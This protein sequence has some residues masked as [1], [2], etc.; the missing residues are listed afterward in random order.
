M[1]TLPTLT[2]LLCYRRRLTLQMSSVLVGGAEYSRLCGLLEAP[3]AS[4]VVSSSAAPY[5]VEGLTP[6]E[7]KLIALNSCYGFITRYSISDGH[8]QGVTYPRHVKGHITGFPNNVQELVKNVLPHPL[9][10]VLDDIHVSWQ[11]AVPKRG[12]DD[13]D[14]IDIQEIVRALLK[15]QNAPGVATGYD[16]VNR[17][18][19]RGADDKG[20]RLY[21][22]GS[23]GIFDLDGWPDITDAGK[24]RHLLE[25]M[26]VAAVWHDRVAEPCIAVSRGEDFADHFDTWYLPRA[27]P[28]LL[29]RGMGGPRQVEE[30]AVA[31]R[32][33]ALQICEAEFAVRR[34]VS[35]RN[36]TLEA[37]EQALVQRH[38]GGFAS[39]LVFLFLVFNIRVRSRNR[40]VSMAS[41]RKSDFPQVEH[42]IKELTAARLEKASIELESSGKTADPAVNQLLRSLSLYGYRQPMSRESRLTMRRK[43]KSYV[44]V[45]EESVFVLVSQYNV[46]AETNER[47]ALHLHGLLWLQGNMHLGTLSR[48]IQGEE[49]VAYRKR[50]IDYVDSIFSED[51]DEGASAVMR[52]KTSVTAGISRLIGN[53]RQFA[54]SFEEANFCAGA[55]Q[56]HTHSPTYVKYVI[57]RQQNEM[58]T[59][60]AH[61]GKW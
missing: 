49:H 11:G 13:H 38:G 45:G 50:V 6:V 5:V 47:G 59:G 23:S 48:D 31:E 25:S 51:L 54:A 19:G 39:H 1:K 42:T 24:L 37:V 3:Q 20:E 2:C 15:E 12:I 40:R 14:P 36:M 16:C 46:V 56:V 26:G 61:L 8:R 55:V 17:D 27:F 21:E 52:A 28:S 34:L 7:E 22:T 29:P 43:I 57:G 30:W 53:T 10:K 4:C 32:E 58:L 44:N 33:A 35:S 41:I 9:L 60:L 18:D